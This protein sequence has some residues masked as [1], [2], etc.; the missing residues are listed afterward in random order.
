MALRSA[1]IQYT[2]KYEKNSAHQ[3]FQYQRNIEVKSIEKY[4]R[5]DYNNEMLHFPFLEKI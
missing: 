4:R 2:Y 1:L 3:N 5:Q